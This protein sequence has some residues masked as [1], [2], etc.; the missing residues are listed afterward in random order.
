MSVDSKVSTG[1]PAVGVYKDIMRKWDPLHE[2][3]FQSRIQIAT[4]F[5]TTFALPFV[6]K[7]SRSVRYD[8]TRDATYLMA[9]DAVG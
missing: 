8:L 6:P 7:V 5:L 3:M 9:Y 4:E 1:A 2:K